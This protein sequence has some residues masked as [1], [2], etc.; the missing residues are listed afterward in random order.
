MRSNTGN[1]G[2]RAVAAHRRVRAIALGAALTALLTTLAVVTA[3]AP[4]DAGNASTAE[5]T[6]TVFAA[7]SLTD[8]LTALGE[9]H[10]QAEP[11]DRPRFSFAAAPV[12]ARQIEA[13]APADIFASASPEWVDY[14]ADRRLVAADSRRTPIGNRLVLITSAASGIGPISL[15]AGVD[16]LTPLGPGRLAVGDPAFVPAGMYAERALTSLGVFSALAPRLAL[17]ESVRA[18]LAL[19]ERGE[20]PLGIV[21]ATDAAIAREVRVVGTFAEASH[22]PIVYPFVIVAGRDRPAVRR[23]F[24]ALTGPAAAPVYRSFGFI[25]RPAAD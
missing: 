14:L 20:A 5:A 18:A 9:R 16:L 22:P 4:V 24:E 23:V 7:A 19:V 11:A 25:T 21:Y 6:V 17:A 2:G 15:E 8:V 12:L 3:P 10:R 1:L 13:G